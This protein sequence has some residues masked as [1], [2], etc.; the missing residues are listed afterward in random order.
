V[1]TLLLEDV[2]SFRGDAPAVDD[3]TLVVLR[4][5]G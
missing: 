5:E 3:L 2:E 4:R 1:G